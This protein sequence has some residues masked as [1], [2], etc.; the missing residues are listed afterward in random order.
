VARHGAGQDIG[1]PQVNEDRANGGDGDGEIVLA[2]I[3][4]PQIAGVEGEIGK[5]DELLDNQSQGE[6]RG[7]FGDI[8]HFFRHKQGVYKVIK[9][10][11][12][13]VNSNSKAT[14]YELNLAL[15]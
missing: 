11:V 7:V 6:I 2:Q 13:K 15:L 12:Y 9:L 3:P 5:R 8:R 4:R 1:E 10:K 14:V